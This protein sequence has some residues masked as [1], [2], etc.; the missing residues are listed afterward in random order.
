[1]TIDHIACVAHEAN[2]VYCL[3]LGDETQVPWSEVPLWQWDSVIAG[4]TRLLDSP[5][6]TPKENHERWLRHKLN[7]GWKYGEEKDPE[8]KTHPCCVLYD[9]L[10]REQQIKDEL[11]L[12]IVRVLGPTLDKVN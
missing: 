6:T 5:A 2:R 9:Q 8:K 12:A 7:N 10:P 3:S 4:V 11:F 1:M